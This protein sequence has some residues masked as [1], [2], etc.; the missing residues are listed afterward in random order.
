MY[1]CKETV[2]HAVFSPNIGWTSDFFSWGILT[3]NKVSRPCQ[4]SMN[5]NQ[6]IHHPILPFFTCAR[7]SVYTQTHTN[8][9][10]HAYT[11]NT[12]VRAHTNTHTHTHT[13]FTYTCAASDDK[14]RSFSGLNTLEPVVI[15]I[16]HGGIHHWTPQKVLLQTKWENK[17]SWVLKVRWVMVYICHV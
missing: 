13:I 8:T 3:N 6:S 10:M 15:N 12:G 5:N 17:E 14:V 1:R 9:S 2:A 16:I 4:I 11:T 7:T